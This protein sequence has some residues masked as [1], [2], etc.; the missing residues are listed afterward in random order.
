MVQLR[1]LSGKQAGSTCSINHFPCVVG[2][3]SSAHVRIEEPGVWDKHV[4]LDLKRPEGFT[5]TALPGALV[6]VNEQPIESHALKGG[7][8]IG[9]GAARLQFWLTPTRQRGFRG[10]EFATWIGLAAL[11]C[12]QLLVIYELLR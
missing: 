11:C 6:T 10:V 4:E 5:L 3:I 7:D 9:I 8:V 2:R 1:I 12:I